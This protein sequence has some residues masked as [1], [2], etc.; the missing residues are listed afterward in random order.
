M[1]DLEDLEV[2]DFTQELE[3]EIYPEGISPYD[4]DAKKYLEK[5]LKENNAHYYGR[6]AE[7]FYRSEAIKEAIELGCS[8]L[9][10]DNMS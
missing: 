8:L 3:A 4:K 6:P 5:Y 10:L 1:K 2:T 9:I 7:S